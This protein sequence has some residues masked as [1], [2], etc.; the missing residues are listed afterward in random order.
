MSV[1]NGKIS[2]R[3][4]TKL[5]IDHT[6]G[7]LQKVFGTTQHDNQAWYF[8][9]AD[10]NRFAK[11]KPFVPASGNG[12]YADHF[13]AAD[14]TPNTTGDRYLAAEA[15]YFGLTQP[16]KRQYA[17]EVYS[18]RDQW[19][20]TRPQQGQHPLRAMDFEAYNHYAPPPCEKV[21]DPSTGEIKV[22]IGTVSTFSFG[23]YI[24][25]PPSGADS[26]TWAD[27]PALATGEGIGAYFLC[28]VF[29]KNEDLSGDLLAKTSNTPLSGGIVLDISNSELKTL[30]NGLYKY[31]FLCARKN[32][33]LN[34]TSMTAPGSDTY[35]ALPTKNG[36]SDVYGKFTLSASNVGNLVLVSV[37]QTASPTSTG[38][39][40]LLTGNGYD[41]HGTSFSDTDAYYYKVN[42]PYR[43]HFGIRITANSGG[44]VS[45]NAS[46]ISLSRTFFSETPIPLQDVTL[47]IANGTTLQQRS[48]V[49]V[50]AGQSTI[51]YVVCSA[52]LLALDADGRQDSGTPAN[53]YF[54]ISVSIHQNGVL[55][56]SDQMRV[57]N[58]D[59]IP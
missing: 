51:V 17:N 7:D 46:Q 40:T 27:L 59:N 6:N 29:A 23:G 32:K 48:T 9:D 21:G 5:A 15:A 33:I 37:S 20:Y 54:T 3:M 26:I 19:T 57:R 16:T 42:A 52:N 34:G 11:F 35:V 13:T 25:H 8:S 1:D 56:G 2:P 41:Y 36:V 12:I 43:I 30:R 47:Y 53:N 49:T 14:G 28:V 44:S 22:A 18:N 39:F 4:G 10:I 55:F 45:L 38:N 31:Y 24:Q 50:P 58:Y